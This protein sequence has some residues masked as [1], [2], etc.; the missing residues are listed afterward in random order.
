MLI[1]PAATTGLT[2]RS[3]VGSDDRNTPPG[4]GSGAGA[5][6]HGLQSERPK[7]IVIGTGF[8]G[9]AS[10]IRLA[11]RGYEVQVF[12]KLDGPGGRAYVHKRDGFVFDAGPTIITVPFLL[13][14]LWALCGK[15]LQDD[16]DLRLMAPFYRIRFDD[17]T[18]FDYTGD[19]QAMREE[20]AKIS[21]S[22]VPGYDR[23]MAMADR[24]Y[25]KGF[26]K[27]GPIAFDRIS[28]LLKAIPILGQMKAWLSL[29]QLVAS[30]FKHPKLRAAFSLQSLLIGGNPFSVTAAYAL[31]ASLERRFGVYSAMGGTGR[32][33]DHLVGLLVE[34]GGAVRY[35][36][37][38]QT[39]SV[40]RIGGK[41]RATGVVL[42]NGER[43]EADLVVCNGDAAWTYRHLIAPEFRRHW[44]DRKIERG[45][46]SM[47]LFVWYFGTKRKYPDVPHHM[48]V[49]GPRYEALL[50]DIFK[51]KVLADDFSLYL[52]RPSATD[53]SLAP[54]GCDCFYVLAPVPH[55][56]GTT[57]WH[58]HAEPYRKAVAQRLSETV[59]PGL[60]EEV[61]CSILTTPQDFQDR[62]WSFKGSGFGLEPTLLQSAYFRPHNRSEDIERLFMVGA[63]THPGAGVPGALIS[64]KVLDQVVP[65]A[66]ELAL[67]R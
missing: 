3:P 2:L 50:K 19:P 21:P 52:H 31:I 33:I 65:A 17:G 12:E 27:L 61:V 59:L 40:Q 28:I 41:A 23:F 20:I 32:I 37:P 7:A 30:Y 5:G 11:V 38:V 62:L 49:L 8:G 55:L 60:E 66:Q 34:Q 35:N 1:N 10:A 47:S 29:H 43:H 13:E 25:E 63:A 44:T 58:A 16:I 6:A 24:C 67:R 51:R 48:M 57:D 18:H 54:E 9:L 46:Y 36:S 53:P 22:D 56:E 45:Q 26:V 42:S 14:E 64:A 15:R 39:I 4:P